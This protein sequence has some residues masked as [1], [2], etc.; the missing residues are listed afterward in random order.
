MELKTDSKTGRATYDR[1][2][3]QAPRDVLDDTGKV[4][5]T[6]TPPALIGAFA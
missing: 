6:Y 3:D 1:I 2:H 4:I 5:G